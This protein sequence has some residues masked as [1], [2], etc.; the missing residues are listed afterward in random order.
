LRIEV[1]RARMGTNERMM[2]YVRADA[3]IAKWVRK[4]S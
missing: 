1:L 3:L 4:N 2:V